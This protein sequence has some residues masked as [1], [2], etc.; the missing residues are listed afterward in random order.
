MLV[1]SC[2]VNQQETVRDHIPANVAETIDSMLIKPNN[3]DPLK[4]ILSF[5]TH[6]KHEIKNWKFLT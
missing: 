5:Y 6:L 2:L 1:V 4:T 3:Y